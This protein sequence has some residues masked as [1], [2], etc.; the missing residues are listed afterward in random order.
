[1]MLFVHRIP[2]PAEQ[3]SIRVNSIWNVTN[4]NMDGD[5]TTTNNNKNNIPLEFM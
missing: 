4:D 5:D 3:T 2:W 1:M